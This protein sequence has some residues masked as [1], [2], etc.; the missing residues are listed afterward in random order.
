[1]SPDRLSFRECATCSKLP[2]MPRLC[3]GC[4]HNRDVIDAL[5]KEII[6][7]QALAVEWGYKACEKGYNIQ[8]TLFEFG[9]LQK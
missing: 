6:I 8:R 7:A 3:D 2:G 1:M 5:K 9:K 4:I